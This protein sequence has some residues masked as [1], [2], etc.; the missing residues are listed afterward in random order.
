MWVTFFFLYYPL[1]RFVFS[2]VVLIMNPSVYKFFLFELPI[3]TF[4][5]FSLD[6]DSKSE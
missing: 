3:I 4:L 2:N 6:N 5:K 1:L